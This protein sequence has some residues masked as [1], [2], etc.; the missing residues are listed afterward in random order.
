MPGCSDK[1]VILRAQEAQT[2]WHYPVGEHSLLVQSCVGGNHLCVY[3]QRID[4]EK[5]KESLICVKFE[6][7]SQKYIEVELPV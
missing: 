4:L 2:T 6:T 5:R 1:P 3:G 7:Q